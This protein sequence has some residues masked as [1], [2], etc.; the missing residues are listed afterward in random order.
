MSE[1]NPGHQEAYDAAETNAEK[2]RELEAQIANNDTA[3]RLSEDLL[4]L[5][6]DPNKIK[7]LKE[8]ISRLQQN[9][10][11]LRKRIEQLSA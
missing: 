3:I 9:N 7:Q 4:M 10:D 6:S 11:A 5:T 2:I 1:L 8:K